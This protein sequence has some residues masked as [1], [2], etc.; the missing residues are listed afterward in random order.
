M[1]AYRYPNSCCQAGWIREV[2]FGNRVLDG[3]TNSLVKIFN[4]VICHH[5]LEQ[6]DVLLLNLKLTDMSKGGILRRERWDMGK[7]SI[8]GERK[9]GARGPRGARVML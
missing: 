9:V 1:T 4:F 8:W 7:G 3:N 6:S 2:T 5:L